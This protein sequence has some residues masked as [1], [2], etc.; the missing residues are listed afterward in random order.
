MVCNSRLV[1]FAVSLCLA[2]APVGAAAQEA[3][4]A[5]QEKAVWVTLGTRAGPV[6]SPVRSQPAN[7]LVHDG[8]YYL[9]DA[10]DGVA[11]QLI[12]RSV[13]TRQVRAVFISHLHF[14]HTAGLAG[15]LGL[16]WQTNASEPL[17][18]YG[19]PGTQELVDGLVASMQP[20]TTAGYGVPGAARIDPR[21]TVKVT[22]LRDT[23]SFGIDGMTVTVRSNTHYSFEP[24]SDLAKRFEAHSIRFDTPGRSIVY[25][26]DTGP[27]DAVVELSRN[28]DLLVAE[29]MDVDLTVSLVRRDAPNLPAPVV[30]G[31]ERHLRDHHLLPSDVGKLARDAQVGSLVVTHFSGLERPDPG[32]FA[33]LR[34]IAEIYDGPVVIANDM[35]AF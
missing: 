8:K 19:P 2:A 22:E 15:L 17:L 7:L 5:G 25:T 26:G 9:V 33:Y 10:G 29:M 4:G 21:D 27:S 34:E 35:D 28:A 16:R 14:D 11:G 32:H 1:A 24:G 30:Q 3:D 18:I 31:M 12:K 13:V 6:A 20:G 23:D